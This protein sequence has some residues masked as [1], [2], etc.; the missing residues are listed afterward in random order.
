VPLDQLLK[1]V[2]EHV[3][4]LLHLDQVVA[5]LEKDAATHGVTLLVGRRARKSAPER[6]WVHEHDLPGKNTDSAATA[7]V[8]AYGTDH[9]ERL[10][11]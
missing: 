5:A 2:F 9:S 4:L 11:G 6:A 3:G 7:D 10:R 1:L 8:T